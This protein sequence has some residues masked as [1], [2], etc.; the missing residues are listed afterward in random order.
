[1]DKKDFKYI[2][3]RVLA[4]FI[5]F[6]IL[7]FI[8]SCKVNAMSMSPNYFAGLHVDDTGYISSNSHID[9]TFY[10]E[11]TGNFDDY[12]ASPFFYIDFCTTG[13]EPSFRVRSNTRGT[14]IHSNKSYRILSETCDINVNGTIYTNQPIYRQI[15][16]IL[17]T[18]TDECLTT[19]DLN[20]TYIC[21]TNSGQGRIYN[22]TD[23]TTA[24]RVMK[25]G[26]SYT[27]PIDDLTY[28]NDIEKMT[29]LNDIKQQ[30]IN[31]NANSTIIG[32]LDTQIQQQ[33]QASQQAHTDS[34]NTQ[35]A[36]NNASSQAHQDSQDIKNS[37]T[38]SSSPTN[39]NSLSQSAGWLPAG[40]VD[41][42][43][44]LPLSL[45]N[46]LSSN[47]SKNCQPVVLPIPLINSN[48]TLPCV[49]TLYHDMGI[50]TFINW[51]G[52]IASAFILLAYLLKLYKWV[53]NTLTF[54]ENNQIDNWGGL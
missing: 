11:N 8:K 22:E 34:Q 33:Q 25:M 9:G 14:M 12:T 44:N 51:V 42:I 36:I 18:S 30:L 5:I 27:Y 41:S 32:K 20:Q 3:R 43:L 39:L 53:D 15:F 29:I 28:L 10:I 50:E 17:T 23:Y 31:N 40:P 6:V 2:F 7:S 48:L 1:M 37:L 54:R 46:N 21:R 49:K 16:T 52:G 4:F 24:Y 19:G 47:L 26:L 45:L 38:D 13:N 35:N